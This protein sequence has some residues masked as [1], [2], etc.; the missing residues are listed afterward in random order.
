MSKV[1]RL[2]MTCGLCLSALVVVASPW[3][4][5]LF[6]QDAGVR[7]LASKTLLLVAAGAVRVLTERR[8][9]PVRFHNNPTL[10][11][12]GCRCCS[13]GWQP[14]GCDRLPMGELADD[15][16]LAVELRR[17]P[18]ERAHAGRPSGTVGRA[19]CDCCCAGDGGAVEVA[20]WES[21]GAVGT[22]RRGLCKSAVLH[23]IGQGRAAGRHCWWDSGRRECINLCLIA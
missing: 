5:C 16:G 3:L 10:T 1:V 21:E 22:V 17:H 19:S 6:T 7:A 15:A 11:A 8:V 14:A 9:V 13:D 4:P 2:G 20:V 23:I 18:G 12:A